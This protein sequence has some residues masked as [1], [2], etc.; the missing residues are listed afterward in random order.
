MCSI[1][2]GKTSEQHREEMSA[3]IGAGR[4]ALQGVEAGPHCAGW[5]YTVG[6]MENFGQPELV[7]TH[8]DMHAN[9]EML[10]EFGGYIAGGLEVDADS[11]LVFG[12]YAF[13]FVPVHPS[14]LAAGLC[15]SWERYYD[16]VGTAPGPLRVLQLVVP[17]LTPCDDCERRRRCLATPGAPG[18]GTDLNRPALNRAARRARSR[19]ERHR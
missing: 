13:E 15:A 17:L 5:V 18:F 8:G 9:G 3:H 6:L 12:D 19:G 11:I 4:W 16:R 14:Y 1:C 7:V 10:N 2:D